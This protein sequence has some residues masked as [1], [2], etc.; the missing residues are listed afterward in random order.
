MNHIDGAVD[1]IE[2]SGLISV[3][4]NSQLSFGFGSI[5]RIYLSNSNFVD[6]VVLWLS[7]GRF[8]QLEQVGCMKSVPN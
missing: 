6:Q 4:G 3:M 2:K 1:Y 7:D 8:V 5:G